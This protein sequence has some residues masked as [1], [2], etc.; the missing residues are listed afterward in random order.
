MGGIPMKRHHF[1][2]RDVLGQAQWRALLIL[3]LVVLVCLTASGCS[4]L[5]LPFQILGEVFELI[6]KLPKPPPGVF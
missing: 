2:S 4:L 6:K 1:L 3:A 5:K